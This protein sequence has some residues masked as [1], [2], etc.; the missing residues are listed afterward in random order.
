MTK[1]AEVTKIARQYFDANDW[2]FHV[3]KVRENAL[4]LAKTHKASREVVELAALLH[5]VARA[6]DKHNDENH[7]L[8]GAKYAAKLLL[9]LGYS[10][11]IVSAVVHCIEAHRGS[12]D[13]KP[14]TIE[15]K[16]M[17]NADAM[18]HFDMMPLFFYWRRSENAFPEIIPW[19]EKKLERDWKKK[20]TL[21]GA[22]KIV[23]QK[24]KAIQ[25][26]LSALK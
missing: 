7:H 9:R 23:A 4:T 5:D 14:R 25:L 21:P 10:P 13:L 24:Y 3:L 20:L 16:I 19:L 17:A 12:K 18:S 22:K 11:K 26:L 8:I 15:A 1:I 2:N 6:K